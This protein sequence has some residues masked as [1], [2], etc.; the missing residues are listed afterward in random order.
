[1]SH[2]KIGA[3]IF[4]SLAT[5]AFAWASESDELQAKAKAMQHEAAE[6]AERGRGEEAEDLERKALAMLKESEHSERHRPDRRSAEIRKM[7]D[8]LQLLRLEERELEQVGGKEERVGDVRRESERIEREL[9]EHA[10]DGHDEE[11][12]P[13][14]EIARRLEHMRVAEEH[15]HHAG[16]HE[17]AEHVAERAKATERELREHR[18]H[19]EGDPIHEMMKQLEEIR[20]EVGRLRHEVKELKENR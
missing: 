14:D 10:H 20:H 19:H 11:R 5:I 18:R 8:R 12:G 15:L 17:I 16:L 2:I 13:Q 6:L 1:M 7:Q 4:A 3:T 9:H